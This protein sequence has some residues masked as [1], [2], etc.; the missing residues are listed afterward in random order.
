MTIL[1]KILVIVNFVFSLIAT[2][3]II[4]VYA[5]ST[6]WHSYA[7]KLNAQ[8]SV[9]N[10]NA[11]AYKGERD[12]LREKLGKDITDLDAKL[13]AITKERNDS[14]VERDQFKKN[15]DQ[16]MNARK[17]L[18]ATRES[19]TG[20]LARRKDEIDKLNSLLTAGDKKMLAVEKDKKDLRDRAV[21]A[22][23]AAKSEHDRNMNLL[24][25]YEAM[26]KENEKLRSGGSSLAGG[27]KNP[28][29]EDVAGTVTATD[30]KTGYL[31]LSIGSDAGLSPGNTLEVFRTSPE[32]RYLGTVQIL[33]VRPHDSVAKPVN[34][35]ARGQIQAGDRVASNISLRR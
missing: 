18:D 5:S 15:Y 22:E 19:L 7:D 32:P 12:E 25:Q 26:V 6:N 20:E 10:S 21:A 16:E 33:A 14:R 3:L 24:A 8:L 29:P 13:A 11:E 35:S 28:P 4:A 30:S 31:E 34:G 23:L 27:R 2:G 17:V 1:G 9:A